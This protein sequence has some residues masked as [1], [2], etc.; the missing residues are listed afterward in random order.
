[1][2]E[3]EII[4]IKDVDTVYTVLTTDSNFLNHFLILVI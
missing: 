3:G 4:K 2:L 1:M